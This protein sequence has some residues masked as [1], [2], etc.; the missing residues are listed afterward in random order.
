MV[1]ITY[2]QKATFDSFLPLL[3]LKERF[4]CRTVKRLGRERRMLPMEEEW[5]GEV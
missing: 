1:I 4:K 5:R 3:D 2:G